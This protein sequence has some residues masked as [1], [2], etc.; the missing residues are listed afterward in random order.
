MRVC[1]LRAAFL[2]VVRPLPADLNTRVLRPQPARVVSGVRGFIMLM[3]RCGALVAP[4]G[5]WCLRLLRSGGEARRSAAVDN[6][7]RSLGRR[8]SVY[9]RIM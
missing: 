1:V 5:E 7:K 6:G 8:P 3:Q 9:R 4:R 2:T